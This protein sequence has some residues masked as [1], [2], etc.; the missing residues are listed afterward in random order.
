MPR[1]IGSAAVSAEG[2]AVQTVV[3]LGASNLTRGFHT[4]VATSRAVWGAQVQ[5]LAALGHGR[6][7]GAQ[8]Q[9]IVR[10]LPG[11][12]ESGLWRHLETHPAGATRAL[13]TDVGNDILYG[14]PAEQVLA[15]IEEAVDRLARV[16]TDITVT[17]LPLAS[18]RRLSSRKFLLFRSIL[19]PSCRL[20]LTRVV[21]T[22]ERVNAGLG[23]LASAR[24]LRFSRLNPE[25]YGIDPIHIRPSVWRTAWQEILG[26]GSGDTSD[27]N[28]RWEGWQLY[29]KRPERQWVCGV[30]QF[31]PQSGAA[32]AAGARVSLF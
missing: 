26:V 32:L 13:V 17:D 6:A 29:L 4:V 5:V 28:S 12:L 24:G 30:E 19:A 31:T 14:F 1:H 18:I 20:S 11:I 10:T 23:L 25:W 9:F 16:T 3:T 8:S 22:A 21:E 15:W 2:P 7:Y 27:R